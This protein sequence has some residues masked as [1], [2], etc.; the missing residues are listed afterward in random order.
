MKH[1]QDHLPSSCKD[2]RKLFFEAHLFIIFQLFILLPFKLHLLD[3]GCGTGNYAKA[4]LDS[5]IGKITLVDASQGMLSKAEKKLQ[6]YI[7]EN[8][9]SELK[10]SHLP[11]IP[12]EESSFDVV[13]FIQVLHHL[14][15]PYEGF[16]NLR[17]CIAEA[18]RVLKPGGVLVIDF[19]THDQLRYGMWYRNLLPRSVEKNCERNMSKEELL[20]LLE[21]AGFE[22]AATIVCPW[23]TILKPEKYFN[24][25][26]PL[27]DEWRL[28]DSVWKLAEMEG[29]LDAALK[30]L[31]EKK[32]FG[33]FDDWFEQAERKRKE[34]GAK[35]GLFVQ[36]PFDV[37]TD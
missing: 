7:N 14:D 18:K 8:R 16:P 31:N 34:V 27:E 5:G 30:S 24:K 6:S 13:A 23:E 3:A 9:V 12:F 26:G 22:K 4:F 17:K 15:K 36:K 32:V 10:C 33:M 28:M 25:D 21:E 19:C 2:S 20:S 35:T 1:L 29:E 11:I 37:N